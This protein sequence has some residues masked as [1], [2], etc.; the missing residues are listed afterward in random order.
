MSIFDKVKEAAFNQFI[1][2]IEWLDNSGNT[3][4]YRFP[5]AGQEI[6]N[7][8]QLIV[9]E[10]QVA[11]FVFEGQVADVFSPG[12]Y[13]IDGGNTPILSKL[14]AW[15]YGFNS[16]FKSEVYFVNTKQFTDMKWGTA[17]PVMLRDA[18]F[19]IVRL[20]AFGAYSLRVADPGE[21]IKQVAGT[22]AQFQTEDI[23][24]QLKRAIV[25]EFSDA[26]GEMKIP[27]LD[28]AAQ[29]KE[30]GGAIRAKI[31]EDFRAY[32]LEVTKF[33]V[34]NISLPEEVE[35][36]MDK[37]SSMG[38]LGNADQYMKFQA[39]DALRDAA[40]NEGGGAGL[41]A[42]LG[43]GFA[44]G[45]QMANAFGNAGTQQGGGQSAQHTVA[46]PG[47]G[48]QN[49]V[50]TKF[51][52]DCGTKMEVSK[53]PCVKCGAELREGAKFCSECGASQEK[54][55]CANCQHE[56]APGAKFCPECGTKTES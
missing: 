54:A 44:V 24:E 32:G 28:L 47:C 22:N 40:Q 17:N 5:V 3:I 13:T 41:G 1:E 20:R 11:V 15:K 18:D 52:N 4:L 6:K 38:A 27:A 34:E 37:R 16:P 10:S 51:C 33:Y 43:A 29:Y 39:A 7:G 53:V 42:G 30:L 14:G 9:R 56:L 23:D 19:G 2:V 31:N 50:G 12:R 25:T 48:K 21:F 36:A 45:N 35:K 49:A 8:A 46:C 55:K 26:L